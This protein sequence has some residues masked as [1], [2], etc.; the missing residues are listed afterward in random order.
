MTSPTKFKA[1]LKEL[2]L[3]EDPYSEQKGQLPSYNAYS[4]DGDVTAGFGIR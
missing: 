1:T 2:A 4:A 3:K